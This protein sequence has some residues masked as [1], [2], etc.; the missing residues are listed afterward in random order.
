MELPGTAGCRQD[1][2]EKNALADRIVQRLVIVRAFLEPLPTFTA[3]CAYPII[4]LLIR[5]MSSIL[6]GFSW[7][8]NN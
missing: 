5:F 2:T 3:C 4:S 1:A 8:A 7:L 6:K